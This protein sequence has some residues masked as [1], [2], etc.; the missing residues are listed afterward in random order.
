MKPSTFTPLATCAAAILMLLPTANAGEKTLMHC[1]AW[2]PVKEATAADWEAFY[3]ASDALP[4][5]IKGIVKVWYGKLESPFSQAM[6]GDIDQATFQKYRAGEKVTIPV[7][8]TAR[9]Y[10]MCMEMTGVSALKAYDTD[11]YHKIWNAA[12]EKVRVEGTTTFNILGQ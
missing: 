11:P 9:E 7:Q 12:Y 8:R 2:T 1:F 10:G 3:K 4:K 5:K 6:L